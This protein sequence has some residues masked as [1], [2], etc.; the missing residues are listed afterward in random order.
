LQVGDAVLVEG[1]YGQFNFR[2]ETSRQIWIAGGIGI[3]PFMARLEALAKARDGK[4]IDLFYCTSSHDPKMV[5]DLTAAAEQ[6]GVKLHVW[7]GRLDVERLINA[8]PEWQLGDVWFCG[9][10]AM[11]RAFKA[12]LAAKGL[13]TEHFHQE[14]FEMR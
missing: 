3:T 14:L 4:Q 11:G 12:Q 8:V 10:A 6:A 2:G 7:W 1:P 13:A 5:V 9:P